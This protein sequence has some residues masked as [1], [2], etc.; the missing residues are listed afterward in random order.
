MVAQGHL[1][2]KVDFFVQF[3]DVESVGYLNDC[4]VELL[5]TS[6]VKGLFFLTTLFTP[7]QHEIHQFVKK[8]EPE[9][10][11]WT[12][13]YLRTTVEGDPW[14]QGYLAALKTTHSLEEARTEQVS[15]WKTYERVFDVV[16]KLSRDN[17]QKRREAEDENTIANDVCLS[18]DRAMARVAGGDHNRDDEDVL[19][20]NLGEDSLTFPEVSS[21]LREALPAVDPEVVTET[22][23]AARKRCNELK[24]RFSKAG[25]SAFEGTR[26]NPIRTPVLYDDIVLVVT[27][28]I[29]FLAM[30]KHEAMW[31]SV[32]HGRYLR[33][34]LCDVNTEFRELP[35]IE[36][37]LPQTLEMGAVHLGDYVQAVGTWILVRD[38]QRWESKLRAA[39]SKYDLDLSGSIDREEFAKVLHDMLHEY[40]M[41]ANPSQQQ[42]L[43]AIGASLADE[44]VD[45]M[46]TD[47]DH[48]IDFSEFQTSVAVIQ[49]KVRAI[50]KTVKTASSFV[51]L[52]QQLVRPAAKVEASES[53]ASVPP[54]SKSWF[55]RGQVL[56]KPA[57]QPAVD[58]ESIDSESEA[59]KRTPDKRSTGGM[60]RRQQQTPRDKA[61]PGPSDS[62]VSDDAKRKG[63]FGFGTKKK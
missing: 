20:A 4:A 5:L 55:G 2:E 62:G 23:L 3:V 30:D 60:F 13:E 42:V 16:R 11:K 34:L 54:S 10:G 22:C 14:C 31:L 58:G 45:A 12:A 9:D 27:P 43:E 57:L 50:R 47:G 7:C 32:E 53:K 38:R 49:A 21:L 46:D 40:L 51:A 25:L 26:A 1:D 59:V 8:N 39:F 18:L 41:P 19:E 56:P 28:A 33:V 36:E 6:V 37:L 17:M 35:D 63:L 48:L 52:Q 24:I 44:L 61:P 15:L 29:A